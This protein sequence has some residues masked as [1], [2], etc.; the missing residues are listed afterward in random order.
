MIVYNLVTP[1]LNS[2]LE[3]HSEKA[4]EMKKNRLQ[5]GSSRVSTQRGVFREF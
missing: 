2:L 4:I 1:C 5:G 3:I